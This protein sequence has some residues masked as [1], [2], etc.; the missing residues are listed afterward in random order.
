MKKLL[1]LILS[2]F[3]SLQAS[4]PQPLQRR[5]AFDIGSGKIKLQV[6]DVDTRT[7]KI[8][9]VLFTDTANVALRE[10]LAKSLNG[11]LSLGIQNQAVEAI[12]KLMKQAALYQPE[13]YHG[14]GTEA[15]R[16][17][18]NGQALVER[19]ESEAGLPI[20]IISQEE[21]GILGF[22]S[23]VSESDVDPEKAISWDF[24]GG[25]FQITAKCGDHYCVYQG[26][27]GKVPLKNALLRIQGKDSG[28]T[29]SPNPISKADADQA[30]KFILDNVKDIPVELRQKLSSPEAVVLGVGIHPLWGM[31]NNA[32]YGPNRVLIELNERLNMSDEEISEKHACPKQAAVYVVSNLV[33]AYGVMQALGIHEVHYVGTQGANAV[34]ALLSPQY[35]EE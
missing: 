1:L 17:A 2:I 13:A 21:E 4:E 19:I 7:N 26:R 27:I 15:L 30:V 11:K 33:L 9:S 32:W 24:G 16:L 23:A 6:S 20:T 25:S 29:F 34:G 28:V 10:D 12:D 3:A 14:V 5:A 35:W 22:I 18:E 8:A 31:E